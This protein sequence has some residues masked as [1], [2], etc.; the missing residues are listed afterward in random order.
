M[1]S[2]FIKKM[3]NLVNLIHSFV[4]FC[5]KNEISIID[6]SIYYYYDYNYYFT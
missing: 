6:T 4:L 5:K 3:T 1:I 2:N